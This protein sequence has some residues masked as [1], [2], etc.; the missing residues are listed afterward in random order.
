MEAT[1]RATYTL[2]QALQILGKRWGEATKT[3]IDIDA[4]LNGAALKEKSK[5]GASHDV[6]QVFAMYAPPAPFVGGSPY[7]LLIVAFTGLALFLAG[8]YT[9]MPSAEGATAAADEASLLTKFET[10]IKSRKVVILEDLAADFK[11]SGQAVR[12]RLEALIEMKR[13]DGV[14]DDRG[15]FI[16]ITPEEFDA[17]AAYVHE[18]GRISVSALA[19]ASNS[20]VRLTPDEA[21]VA[22]LEMDAVEAD[23]DEAAGAADGVQAK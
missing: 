1:W 6:Q 12:E 17:V 13:L 4:V 5:S 19:A 11:M 21:A 15:K 8:L 10:L 23:D 20:L 3:H 2:E 18:Q 22:A 16:Y 14:L 9:L 7:V